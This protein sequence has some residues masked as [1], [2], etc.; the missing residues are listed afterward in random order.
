MH[1]AVVVRIGGKKFAEFPTSRRD[2]RKAR[3]RTVNT[4]RSYRFMFGV[5]AKISP[6]TF[7]YVTILWQV[8]PDF[9]LKRSTIYVNWQ[10]EWHLI[11][12]A[13][14]AHGRA[15]CILALCKF[16]QIQVS[17]SRGN[18]SCAIYACIARTIP[19]LT[20]NDYVL[21][22]DENTRERYSH[23]WYSQSAICSI[24]ILAW[25]AR[26]YTKMQRSSWCIYVNVIPNDSE[27]AIVVAV[28]RDRVVKRVLAWNS[29]DLTRFAARYYHDGSIV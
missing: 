22:N 10:K 3:R 14:R 19:L 6:A 9:R 29:M 7:W 8:L 28:T 17:C 18:L 21:T 24:F 13:P 26:Y 27:I 5:S 2:K 16:M 11:V 4:H 1:E 23:L 12:H 20:T 15:H 25:W